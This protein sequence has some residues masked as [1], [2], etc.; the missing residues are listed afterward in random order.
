MSRV[1]DVGCGTGKHA[2]LLSEAGLEVDGLDLE[3]EFVR[4]AQQRNPAGTF[5][6]GDMT[7]FE[8]SQPYDAAV[9]LFRAI[10]YAHDDAGLRS[11]VTCLGRSVRSGG[12]VILEPW[13]EPG[14]ME[15]GYVTM[16]SARGEGLLVC[17]VSRT[18]IV[19]TVSRLEFQYLIGRPGRIEHLS[20]V[21]ELGL[22]RRAAIEDAFQR[23]GLKVTYDPEGLMGRGLYN[24]TKRQAA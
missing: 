2:Q 22:F 3:P 20:E 4:V 5:R 9:C 24:A 10:G 21:H 15:D 6:I 12:L 23:A 11:T 14:T 7:S 8:V 16:H 18:S 17:R 13:F 1:L 19:G